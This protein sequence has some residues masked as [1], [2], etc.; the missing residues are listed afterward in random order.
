MGK[1]FKTFYVLKNIFGQ[2]TKHGQSLE[3]K[4]TIFFVWPNG[5]VGKMFL[6]QINE[7]CEIL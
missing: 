7:K 3:D 2:A 6:Q 5:A 1:L 4:Q